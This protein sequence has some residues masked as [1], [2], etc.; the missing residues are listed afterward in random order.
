MNEINVLIKE[1][2]QMLPQ[3]WSNAVDNRLLRHESEHSIWTERNAGTHSLLA[4]AWLMSLQT[5]KRSP[6]MMCL[7]RKKVLRMDWTK[8]QEVTVLVSTAD[9]IRA[10]S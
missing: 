10:G 9:C 1:A 6:C 5:Q 4:V 2:L 7:G 8:R 3:N